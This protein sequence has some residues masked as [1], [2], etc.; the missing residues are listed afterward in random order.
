MIFNDW[1]HFSESGLNHSFNSTTDMKKLMTFAA[2]VAMVAMAEAQTLHYDR[3]ADYFEEAL[4]IG[5]GT[6]GG[7]VYGGVDRD[8]I[9]LNDPVEG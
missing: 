2:G 9:S 5:N 3:P 1:V 8:R 4:V 7:I 6:M